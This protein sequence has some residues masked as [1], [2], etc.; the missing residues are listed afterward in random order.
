MVLNRPVFTQHR[1]S[2]FALTVLSTLIHRFS[3][4][5]NYQVTVT[6]G[7]STRTDSLSVSLVGTH[8]QVNIDMSKSGNAASAVASAGESAKGGCCCEPAAGRDQ[9]GYSHVPETPAAAVM[10]ES[11]ATCSGRGPW[12]TLMKS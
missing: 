6:G 5:G 8:Q 10:I 12:R 4:A 3:E 11:A 2:S 9:I 1:F 7:G